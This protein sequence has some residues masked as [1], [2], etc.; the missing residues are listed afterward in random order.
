MVLSSSPTTARVLTLMKIAR[1]PV[2]DYTTPAVFW[3][4]HLAH[5]VKL[6]FYGGRS[7]GRL[8]WRGAPGIGNVARARYGAR[9]GREDGV[10][11]SGG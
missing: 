9:L 11:R 6:S 4:V 7:P 5:S 3:A 10:R 2:P 8:R 1:I